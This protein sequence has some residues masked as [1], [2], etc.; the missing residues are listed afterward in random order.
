[1]KVSAVWLICEKLICS[2]TLRR[3]LVLSFIKKRR[4]NGTTT[5]ANHG[6]NERAPI[7]QINTYI[8]V[9]VGLLVDATGKVARPVG[10]Q[11]YTQ[12][13]CRRCEERRDLVGI[14]NQCLR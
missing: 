9:L 7:E 2:G 4:K 14:G 11:S 6:I 8:L 13:L 5:S 12:K 3:L 1:M 10:G